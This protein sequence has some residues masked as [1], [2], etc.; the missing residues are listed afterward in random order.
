MNDR[1][2]ADTADA[3]AL[4]FDQ[5]IEKLQDIIDRIES[6]Q[7]PLEDSL[8]QYAQGMQLVHRC[9][10]I[11]NSAEQRIATLTEQY[12]GKLKATDGGA[13]DDEADA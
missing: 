5:A 8:E 13:D 9:R 12:D 1:S 10:T 11:L 3:A 2:E 7:V 6:G 4:R